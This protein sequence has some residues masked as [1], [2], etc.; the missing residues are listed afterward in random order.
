MLAIHVQL[1]LHH[2][3]TLG[4]ANYHQDA[5]VTEPVTPEGIAA[6]TYRAYVQV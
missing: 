3:V 2:A 4:I 5:H 1:T 6:M